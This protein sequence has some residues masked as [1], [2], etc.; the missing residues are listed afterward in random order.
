MELTMSSSRV[1]ITVRCSSLRLHAREEPGDF[2]NPYTLATDAAGDLFV[3]DIGWI[4]EVAAGTG[5]QTDV[6]NY[7]LDEGGIATDAAGNLFLEEGYG[8]VEVNSAEPP[9]F[10]FG[11]VAVGSTSSPQS[12]TLQNVGTVPLTAVPPGLT[13]GTGFLQVPGSGTPADCTSS[14]SLA[15][16]ATCN[17]SIVF[18]PQVAGTIKG[19]ATFTDNA[20]N[21]SPSASQIVKLK[22]TGIQ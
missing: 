8:L 10:D 12:L 19:A 22:G 3:N 6:N 4:G 18:A 7:N 16:G 14:F 20:L 5:I 9:T 1:S 13:V 21:Q 17:L 11:S 2:G 15:L